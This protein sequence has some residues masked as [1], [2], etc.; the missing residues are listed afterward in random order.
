MAKRRARLL[1]ASTALLAVL[2]AVATA[3]AAEPE[4]WSYDRAA[5]YGTVKSHVFVPMSDGTPIHCVLAQP[6]VDGAA[7]PGQFPALITSY[8]PY[9]ALSVL[10]ALP[11]NDYWASRG[12]VAMSCD[13]RGTGS[14]GGVWQGLL[15]AVENQDNYELLAWMRRQ[16][17]SNGRLGQLGV[18][19]GG[20]TAMRVASLDPPGL[21]AISPV[22]AQDDLYREDIYPGGI[23]STPGTGDFWPV[24]TTAVSGGRELAPVT[25]AQYLEHPLWDDFWK[26]ISMWT[27]WS[28]FTTPILAIGGWNDTLVPGGAPAN[29]IGLDAAGHGH[30]YLIMGP[31]GHAA[32]GAPAPLPAGAQLAWFDRW[33]KELP[34]APLPKSIMTTYEQPPG[35]A[36]RG[37]QDF[38]SWPPPGTHSVNWALTAERKIAPSAGLA[39]MAS[40]TTLPTDQ[41][42]SGLNDSGAIPPGQRVDQTLVFDTGPLARDLVIAGRIVVKLKAALNHTDGNFKAVIYDIAPDGSVTFL[43]E[44]YLKASHRLSHE[45]TTAVKP[46]A[47]HD[48]TIEIFPM[49]WRF[50]AGHQLRL[51]IYGGHST[52]LTPEP[53]PVTTTLSLGAGGSTVVLPV[54]EGALP[55]LT[56]EPPTVTTDRAYGA[57]SVTFSARVSNA[58]DADATAM[59]ARFLVDGSPLGPDQTIATLAAG[60]SATVTST[61]WSAKHQSGAHTVRIVV[62]PGNSIAESDEQNNAAVT[63]FAVQGNKIR[64]G[65]FEQSASG[66]APNA[67]TASGPT[68]YSS[69]GSDGSRSASTTAGGTWTSDAVM[70]TPGAAH[71][72]SVRASGAGGTLIV[73][74]LAPGGTVTS[75]SLPLA[76]GLGFTPAEFFVTPLP[77]TVQLRV[78]LVGGLAGTTTFDDVEVV[79]P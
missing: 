71:E 31:W 33:L 28:R 56:V 41:G 21:V 3:A 65:S 55:D 47:V 40:Y 25:Y 52:E 17:W 60:A 14:S 11:G 78:V 72:V 75:S 19:Y 27:K 18:S 42:D 38:P 53:V 58:G 64:N 9:G 12:Y 61:A 48:Y 43:N 8:T 22:A 20:M 68:S 6:A 37:W 69:G 76:A 49:H 67:W 15:S 66:A 74:Q 1:A 79:G 26:Q 73:E 44:G 4:W 77:T 62:D 10:G 32:T 30:N 13:V 39:E 57:D 54:L 51:R 16:E 59:T 46:G 34:G 36:G 2:V 29:W 7:A 24:F 70:V 35:G 63:S 23:K 50:A 5:E 45:W